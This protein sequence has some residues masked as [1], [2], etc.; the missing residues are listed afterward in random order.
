M[1]ADKE[2]HMPKLDPT[3]P[4]LIPEYS[5]LDVDVAHKLSDLLSICGHNPQ[6]TVRFDQD[7]YDDYHSSLILEW[8]RMETEAEVAARLEKARKQR[9]SVQRAREARKQHEATQAA[10]QLVTE[11]ALYEKLRAKFEPVQGE[12][13]S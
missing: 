9:A 7:Y 4:R 10:E 11:R 12:D 3:Q 6:A 5:V 8:Q 2:I 1:M 13:A